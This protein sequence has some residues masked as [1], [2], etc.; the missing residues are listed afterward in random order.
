MLARLERERREATGRVLAAQESERL[1]IAQ[2]LHDQ[3]G[4]EL[5][6]VLLGLSRLEAEA[7][8]KLRSD[9]VMIQDVVRA[10]LDDV[11]RISIELRPEALADLGLPSALVVLGQRLSERLG[12]QVDEL[13]CRR[14]ARPSRGDGVGGVPGGPGGPDQSG[15]PLRHR[16]C[17][18]DALTPRRCT[19]VDR[20]DEERG[21]T[22]G[23]AVGT[24]MRGMR[25][26]AT[27][28]GAT[29]EIRNRV[30]PMGREVRLGVSPQDPA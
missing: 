22:P 5:T 28:L 25:E 29:L 20:P 7:P 14:P 2:E 23:H 30:S 16:P 13:D 27:L 15:A 8:V 6:A 10:S 21:L 26:C 11:R 12:L 1:R 3:V 18:A 19:R 9:V 17:R 24:G 4:Q